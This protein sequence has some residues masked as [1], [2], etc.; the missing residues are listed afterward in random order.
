MECMGVAS[1]C[2][3]QE[4]GVASGSGWNLWVWLV[5]VVVRRY[6][7]FLILLIPTPLV[8]VLFCSSI[9]TFCSFK[10]KNFIL[11]IYTDSEIIVLTRWGSLRLAPIIDMRLGQITLQSYYRRLFRALAALL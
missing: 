1:G 9:P 2:G 4:V 7:D 8:S 6:I 3:E 11:Y 10:K 5:G